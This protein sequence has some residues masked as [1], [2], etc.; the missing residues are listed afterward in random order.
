MF[1]S[2]PKILYKF[3]KTM[4]SDIME[5]F[6]A[7]HHQKHN[8]KGIPLGRDYNI[9][10][11]WSM[12]VPKVRAMIAED[13]FKRTY[14]KNFF[15]SLN[16]NGITECRN[17]TTEEHIKFRDLLTNQYKAEINELKMGGRITDT[18]EK[19]YYIMLTKKQ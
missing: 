15:C 9:K 2:S 19:V 7:E 16:Y 4:S 12:W 3:G 17:W 5:R 11:I 13:W 14:P 8:W 10:P 6:S 18:H 1:V